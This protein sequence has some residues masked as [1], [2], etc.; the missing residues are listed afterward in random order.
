MKK[1]KKIL[2]GCILGGIVGTLISCEGKGD[3]FIQVTSDNYDQSKFYTN[4]ENIDLI[5]DPFVL[6]TEDGKYYAYGTSDKIQASGYLAWESDDL[7]TWKEVGV[8]YMA[9][10]GSWS[11]RDYWAPEVYYKNGKYYMYYTAR[12][13]ET[14]NL[15]LGVAA[16][17][18]PYGPFEDITNR[19]IIGEEF[20]VID[21]NILMEDGKMYLYYVKDCSTNQINGKNT[22]QIYGVELSDDMVTFKGEPVLLTTP[23]QEWEDVPGEWVWN[24]GPTILKENDRYYLMYS[25]HPYWDK[26]Y[27]IGYAVSDNPLGPFEKYENN[28]VLTSEIEWTHV[29][30]SGHNSVT[31]S[32]DGKEIYS[33]YHTHM[34]PEDGG[35]RRTINI[36]KLGFREDGT[37]YIN[38]PSVTP[39][40]LPSGT[41]SSDNLNDL[42]ESIEVEGESEKNEKLLYDGEIVY[43]NN[44]EDYEWSGKGKNKLTIKLKE[45]IK[46][47]DILI[48]GNVE[49]GKRPEIKKIKVSKNK[50]FKGIDSSLAKLPGEATIISFDEVNTKEIVIEFSNK[51]EFVISE[52]II[53]GKKM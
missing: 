25:A 32:K 38:G 53:M 6:R 31:K 21:A 27:S 22:S 43:H 39:Q 42:I 19:P 47:T 44:F 13:R 17:D 48:Y 34:N 28:P 18:N 49:E 9:K 24:E 5:A 45:E 7:I 35:S 16:S 14:K 36:D 12:D 46:A 29:S 41:G 8:A 50:T 26:L 51:E 1:Y 30:G 23:E 2:V 33:V 52:L 15:G 3:S 10:R 4:P 40:P 20:A 37:M 11:N